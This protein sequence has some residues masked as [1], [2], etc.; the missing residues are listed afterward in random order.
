MNGSG[1]RSLTALY[2]AAPLSM[3]YVDFYTFLMP[4]YTLSLATSP[5]SGHRHRSGVRLYQCLDFCESRPHTV[6][7]LA[8]QIDH[9]AVH[10]QFGVFGHSLDW[11]RDWRGDD[12]LELRAAG[13]AGLGEGDVQAFQHVFRRVDVAVETIPA[14]TVPD[15]AAQRGIGVTTDDDRNMRL[16]NGLRIHP[17]CFELHPFALEIDDVF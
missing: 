1:I 9:Q 2:V 11:H 3:G 14:R 13:R 5:R 7:P 10:A 17:H 16:L 4:L 8:A 12:D 15:R 6:R